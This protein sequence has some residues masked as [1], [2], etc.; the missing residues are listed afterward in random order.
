[1]LGEMGA[2]PGFYQ[3]FADD[4][5]QWMLLDLQTMFETRRKETEQIV[6]VVKDVIF[7]LYGELK[8]SRMVTTMDPREDIEEWT[9]H[10]RR[11]CIGYKKRSAVRRDKLVNEKKDLREQFWQYD[12]QCQQQRD[13]WT[14]ILQRNES[15]KAQSSCRETRLKRELSFA[16]RQVRDLKVSQPSN[17]LKIGTGPALSPSVQ[18]LCAKVRTTHDMASRSWTP[19]RCNCGTA[20][21]FDA[22][23]HCGVAICASCFSTTD[24]GSRPEHYP[25]FDCR[26]CDEIVCGIVIIPDHVGSPNIIQWVNESKSMIADL[27]AVLDRTAAD[28]YVV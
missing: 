12:A 18:D 9:N 22:L 3:Q 4:D 20:Q 24:N 25:F 23:T 10:L 11:A 27:K 16:K 2:D 5:L 15:D 28:G 14:L 26:Y 17:E 8:E 21:G 1:M 13:E 19:K 7:D 6:Q